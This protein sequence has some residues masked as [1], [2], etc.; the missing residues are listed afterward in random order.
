MLKNRKKL[1]GAAILC[2]MATIVGTFAWTNFDASIINAWFGVGTG[3]NQDAG[4]GGTLHNNHVENDPSKQIFV[5]NWG[6]EELFV[7]IRL[8]EYMEQGEGAG[9]ISEEVDQENNIIPNPANKATPLVSGTNINE[10]TTWITHLLGS[11][12]DF[13]DHW[14]WNM[15]GQTYF[16]PALRASRTDRSFVN[17]VGNTVVTADS[18]ND[19][20]ERA[21]QTPTAQVMTMAEWNTA[22]N[23]VGDYWV[24]DTDGWAYW[25]SPIQPGDATGVLLHEVTLIS[26]QESDY[27][28]GI[29]VDAQMA[30]ENGDEVDG[31]LDN[32][33]RFGDQSNGGWTTDGESL[34]NL[35]VASNGTGS[36][37]FNDGT[38][39][40][41]VRGAWDLIVVEVTVLNGAITS[42]ETV[43]HR[44]TQEYWAML[45][46]DNFFGRFVGLNSV[47][48]VNGVDA[49]SEATVSAVAVREAVINAIVDTVPNPF[50]DGTFTG[51][52]TG[53]LD[54]IVVEVTVLNGA[55]ASV[56][57]VSQQETSENW[58]MLVSDNFFGRFDGLGSDV[59]VAE[60]Y[61][62]FERDS[63][64][65]SI[66]VATK[67]AVIDALRQ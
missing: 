18:E 8:S 27:F 15:G 31:L 60:V 1:I 46:S 13:R 22:G 12:S 7:R 35:I 28:Y 3:S 30:T 45:I 59:E 42:V 64:A 57:A 34:M 62:A 4:P 37:L 52:A 63:E 43:F 2:L 19:D 9:E 11:Q 61:I 29:K 6:D 53:V 66:A 14:E 17:N 55:I 48:E 51:T 24:F 33:L 50:N 41:V 44:E 23:P 58:D 20:G 32:Y 54:E 47:A 65:T 67:A 40:G 16:L 25:A 56:E 10:S 38:F 39:T 36:S 21:I 5:E 49:V 26:E